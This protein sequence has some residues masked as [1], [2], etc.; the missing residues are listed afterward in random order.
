[1][2]TNTS[3]ISLTATSQ[4]TS[5]KP[6]LTETEALG[7]VRLSRLSLPSVLDRMLFLSEME[8][9]LL[10]TRDQRTCFARP[11]AYLVSPTRRSTTRSPCRGTPGG[12]STPPLR[13]APAR[14]GLSS[15]TSPNSPAR[16]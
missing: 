3:R 10:R 7:P 8:T 12:T 14:E 15:P 9:Q 11:T 5:L 13:C 6:T 2:A 1:M 16:V 4:H